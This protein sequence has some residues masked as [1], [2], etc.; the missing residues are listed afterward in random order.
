MIL[1]RYRL[2]ITASLLIVF[3]LSWGSDGVA[4]STEFG[5]DGDE[6]QSGS[7]SQQ[8]S[9]KDAG[10]RSKAASHRGPACLVVD[11]FFAD[12]VWG[13]VGERTCL[14]CHNVK[15]DAS[16]SEFLLHDTA[17]DRAKRA[18]ALRHNLTAFLRMA[19][20]KEEGA[21]RLL[22]KVVGDLDHGGREVL[23]KDSTGYRVLEQF[24]RLTASGYVSAASRGVYPHGRA[25]Q[26][27]RS[28]YRSSTEGKRRLG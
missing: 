11:N 10:G 8:P 7:A 24:V 17:S 21:S 28:G 5:D 4:I 9:S 27:L 19:A 16:D 25:T 13:K 15:G 6:K 14:K 2:S 18:D 20:A 12:E 1:V 3:V 23:K 22:L 26:S